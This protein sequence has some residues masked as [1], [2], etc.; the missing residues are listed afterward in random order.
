MTRCLRRQNRERRATRSN[1]FR[2]AA[3][4][5]AD[6]DDDAPQLSS[7]TLAALQSFLEDKKQREQYEAQIASSDEAIPI[8]EKLEEDW[9]LSQFWV[10]FYKIFQYILQY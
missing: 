1:V 6:S 8:P 10:C 7:H 9:N 3:G 5:M 2:I 4:G